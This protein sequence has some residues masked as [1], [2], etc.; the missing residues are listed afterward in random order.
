ME[1]SLL[2]I[3]NRLNP[4]AMVILAV[5]GILLFYLP[6]SKHSHI[7]IFL[8]SLSAAFTGSTIP[9]VDNM[10]TLLR[11]LSIFLLLLWGIVQ[12]KLRVSWGVL[13]FWGYVFLGFIF[14]FRAIS[15]NWQFQRGL[16][17]LL[18]AIAMPFAYSNENYRSLRLSLVSISIAGTIFSFLSFLSIPSHLGEAEQFAGFTDKSTQFSQIL[19]GFL[20]FTLWSLWWANRFAVKAACASGFFLGVV[21]LILGGTRGATIAGMLSIFPL[22]LT[23]VNRKNMKWLLLLVIPP[24][25]LGYILFQ[26]SSEERID[27]LL[28]RYSLDAGLS[29][30]EIFWERSFSEI[31]KSPLLGRGIG[32]AENVLSDSFH[33]AYLEIWFNT[34]LFGLLLFLASLVCFLYRI[35]YLASISND[36]EIRS[37]LALALGYMMGFIFMCFFESI[38]AGASNL[39][40]ILYLFLG[41]LVSN[42][43]LA[44]VNNFSNHRD[45][46]LAK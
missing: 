39:N 9:T 34:G 23:F 24:L 35:A 26:H 44:R 40:I 37:L 36:S 25:L 42:N 19:G 2:E 28:K 10:A 32:A 17:L 11:L 16:L 7:I 8:L 18:L 20:P 41:V 4:L 21:L 15:M 31:D 46:L 45:P 14:M 13:F 12:T 3:I 29:D 27:F 38:G 1:F 22:L 33:N 43:G 5:A 6:L 30:R